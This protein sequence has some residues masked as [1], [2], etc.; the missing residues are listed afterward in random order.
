M[1]TALTSP[2]LRHSGSSRW[3]FA[4]EW[5]EERLTEAPVYWVASV[6]PENRPHVTPIWGVWVDAAFWMEGGPNTRRFRNLK[7]NPA[8]V[9]TIE[10]GN[11]ALILEGDAELV[12]DLDDALTQRLLA[13]FR[14]YVANPWLR[15]A[16]RQLARRDLARPAAQGSGL[17][18]LS[19]RYDTLEFRIS[20]VQ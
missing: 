11:D 19:G 13:G 18:Q 3:H 14:K 4:L 15:G 8:T 17:E 7:L 10:R 9:V 6:G 16:S 5:A 1:S 2:R 20:A 12:T